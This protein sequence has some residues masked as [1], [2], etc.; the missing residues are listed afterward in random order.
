MWI[1]PAIGILTLLLFKGAMALTED[2]TMAAVRQGCKPI[3]NKS[4]ALRLK[5]YLFCDYDP[6]VRPAL[7]H[8]NSINVTIVLRP[9]TL[10]F[11]EWKSKIQL[12]SWMSY[13]WKD[14]HLTWNPVD[15]DGIDHIQIKSDEIWVP[16]LFVYNSGDVSDQ[17]RGIPSTNCVIANDGMILCVPTI[18][19]STICDTDFTKWPFDVHKCDINLGSWS[20]TGEEITFILEIKPV[21][22]GEYME[23]D[24]WSLKNMSGKVEVKK[25]KCCP[26]DT[27][28]L[29]TYSFRIERNF[30][31]KHIIF[32]TPAVVLMFLTLTV[33]W[34]DSNTVERLA[35][36]TINFICHLICMFD[37]HWVLPQNG[38][39]PPNILIFYRDSIGLATFALV[40]TVAVRKLKSINIDTPRWLSS[41]TSAVVS[42]PAGRF[43]IE[44]HED[45]KFSEE[46]LSSEN[47]DNAERSATSVK[48]KSW[49][50]FAII[51]EWLAFFCV[52]LT[53]IIIIIIL[54][55][56]FHWAYMLI[57]HT[58]ISKII[59]RSWTTNQL[60]PLRMKMRV[61]PLFIVI[62]CFG[63]T[64]VLCNR[65]VFSQ[66][67]VVLSKSKIL[68]L[69]RY[70]ICE[71]D[72]SIRPRYNDSGTFVTVT[73]I[74]K[75]TDYNDRT[76]VLDLHTWTT[77][78]WK[79]AHLSWDPNHFDGIRLLQIPSEE[80]WTPDIVVNK[81]GFSN[82][83]PSIPLS[84]CLITHEGDV[85]C[86]PENTY[87]IHCLPDRRYWPYDW[88]VC[89]LEMTS[90]STTR[91]ELNIK[92]KLFEPEY[93]IN[94]EWHLL[95]F[96]VVKKNNP[97][98]F[99]KSIEASAVEFQF[100]F[101]RM[102]QSLYAIYMAPII[103]KVVMTLT[104][105]W[106]DVKSNERMIL[107][108]LNFV[109][110]LL[111]LGDI[112]WKIPPSGSS[113]PNLLILYQSSLA[114]AVF[115]LIL[116]LLLRHIQKLEKEPPL[117][118]SNGAITILQS[119]IGK[120][121]LLSILDP[122]TMAN[123]DL[124][125]DDHANLV[126]FKNTSAW[127]YIAVLIS[128][129]AFF[130]VL[131]TYIIILGMFLPGPMPSKNFI[132]K[133]H[134]KLKDLFF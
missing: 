11:E 125:S 114:L 2:E 117:W 112:H 75:S 26:N 25:F 36:A 63:A 22:M 66:C 107:A 28:P 121:L 104:T 13:M 95:G 56:I 115:A 108:T 18:K 130:S 109:G 8:R 54:S 88:M 71:Y 77:L 52:L 50:E 24:E 27:F 134:F 118:I 84:N 128:W 34:L 67:N 78:S 19:Y 37:M 6:A 100:C 89:T 20:H 33:L 127:Q 44:S 62:L 60:I 21:M 43:F 7:N 5:T 3:Q 16:D 120:I 59:S 51:I 10:N 103:A 90:W 74:P 101:A 40:I 65:E 93:K 83:K 30:V 123:L 38:T 113:P 122:K 29:I 111:C 31:I 85:K 17:S 124:K 87:S 80:I 106:L 55:I 79:D 76:N 72:K 12:Y 53:Y 4:A 1:P 41:L 97:Y 116:T 69:K 46:I 14:E 68:Q 119:K 94:S 91:D 99:Y 48:K 110:H 132:L 98:L 105:L 35:V 96:Q 64:A 133:S 70:I 15:Y 126:E 9:R 32:V 39:N 58:I 47:D 102:P 129:F 49:L 86:V 81:L 45:F 92:A 57:F 73:V 42:N 23:N 82:S 61:K 131:I